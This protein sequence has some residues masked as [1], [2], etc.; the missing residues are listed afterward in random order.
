MAT[1]HLQAATADQ[2]TAVKSL[3]RAVNINPMGL[4]W[5]RF[6]VAVDE[7]G[8]VIG[9]GQVKPHGDGSRE[10]A[11]IAVAPGWRRQGVAR[12]IIQRLQG[13]H[14]PPLWLTCVST[15]IPFYTPFGFDEVVE[16]AV[17]PPYFRRVRRL[18]NLFARFSA[19]TGYLAV[20]IWEG[21]QK[22]HTET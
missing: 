5:R 11:S 3:I 14:E 21:E 20:M 16:T 19:Q 4:N 1:Y 22:N 13:E 6:L 2:E 9:C 12:A 15:L 18:F 17:M 7:E 8:A 10:L